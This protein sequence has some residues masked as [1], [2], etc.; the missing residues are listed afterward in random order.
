[1]GSSCVLQIDVDADVMCPTF[2]YTVVLSGRLKA[3]WSIKRPQVCSGV[4]EIDADAGPTSAQLRV[5]FI[6]ENPELLSIFD[7]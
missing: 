3:I 5:Q 1:M 2:R 4:T 7:S 6:R